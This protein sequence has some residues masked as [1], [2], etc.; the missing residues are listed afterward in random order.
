MAIAFARNVLASANSKTLGTT[1]VGTTTAVAN[2]GELVVVVFGCF[3]LTAST[4]T[5]AFTDSVGG[6]TWTTVVS[7]A[8]TSGTSST[9]GADT[10]VSIGISKLTNT[11]PSGGTITATISGSVT[12]KALIINAFTGCSTTVRSSGNTNT[13][14]SYISGDLYIG[15]ISGQQASVASADATMANGTWSGMYAALTTGGAA[16][17][18]VSVGS[19]YAIVTGDGSDSWSASEAIPYRQAYLVL[20]PAILTPNPAGLF[21]TRQART[22]A[23]V[24]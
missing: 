19:Q 3:N 11:I 7:S 14:Y 8:G 12:P 2:A 20:Q 21:I 18:N 22:R 5:V 16:S 9:A 10:I 23:A 1:L 17:S 24:R 13:T 4:P 6:N 15:G